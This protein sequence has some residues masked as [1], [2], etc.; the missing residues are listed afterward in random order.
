MKVFTAVVE[1][2]PETNLFVGYVP[3][4]PGAHTQAETLDELNPS[5]SLFSGKL[6]KNR[7]FYYI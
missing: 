3:G 4:F 7:V 2:C 1:K 5:L 6:L